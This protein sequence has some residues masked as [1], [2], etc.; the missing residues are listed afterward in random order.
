M[1]ILLPVIILGSLGAIFGLWLSIVS[2]IFAVR[3]DPKTEHIFSLLPGSNC[4]ACGKAGCYGLAEALVSG[5]VESITCPVVNDVEKEDI[6]DTLGIKQS[7]AEKTIATL[8][9]GGGKTCKDKFDYNGPRDCNIAIHLMDGPKGCSFGCIGMGSCVAACP[10]DA[11]TMDENNLPKID[12]EK[13]TSCGKCIKVCPKNVLVLAPLKSEHHIMC[14]SKDRGVDVMKS[15]KIGCI[16]CGK[17]V[18]VCP[19]EAIE[20]N[21]NLAKIDYLK[22]TNCG[23]CVEACPTKAIKRR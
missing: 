15:C 20:L 5:E 6:A 19:V 14:N 3:K 22:C 17:C 10:F 18:K 23:A 7:E 9:C 2:K 4:G 8:I 11:I 21:N 13:C 1:N 12:E 16:G